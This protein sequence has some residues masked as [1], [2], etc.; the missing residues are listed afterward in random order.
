MATG[1]PRESRRPWSS[2]PRRSGGSRSAT[3]RAACPSAIFRTGNRPP[4]SHE[5]GSDADAGGAC[6]RDEAIVL[7]GVGAK[8]PRHAAPFRCRCRRVLGGPDGGGQAGPE[9]QWLP[10]GDK[11]VHGWAVAGGGVGAGDGRSDQERR[12][13]VFPGGSGRDCR[14]FETLQFCRGHRRGAPTTL[15]SRRGSR[16]R[17]RRGHRNPGDWGNGRRRRPTR[18]GLGR[19]ARRRRAKRPP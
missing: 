3:D 17:D 8:R 5:V 10:N 2:V 15:P 18:D 9:K 1:G 16:S 4:R 12:Q 11:G 6:R 14:G 7:G 13:I 19:V